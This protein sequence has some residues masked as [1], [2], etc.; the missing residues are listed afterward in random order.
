MAV[1]SRCPLAAIPLCQRRCGRRVQPYPDTPLRPG[2]ANWGIGRSGDVV[3]TARRPLGTGR[4]SRP[5]HGWCGTGGTFHRSCPTSPGPGGPVYWVAHSETNCP[6]THRDRPER[7]SR[8]TRKVLTWVYPVCF[9]PRQ[10]DFFI[11]STASRRRTSLS[12]AVH[13]RNNVRPVRGPL[14]RD[15]ERSLNFLEKRYLCTILALF[16]HTIVQLFFL[17]CKPCVVG[18]RERCRGRSIKHIQALY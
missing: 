5:Q 14:M 18:L 12:R 7:V 4:R 10:R 3:V 8:P 17:R 15:L 1:T 6:T 9:K 16:L 13:V 11:R 2:S